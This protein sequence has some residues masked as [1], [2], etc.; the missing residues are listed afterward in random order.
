MKTF[1]RLLAAGVCL[2]AMTAAAATGATAAEPKVLNVYN[3]SDYI[4][5]DTLEKFTAETGI[6]VQYDVYDSNEMLE[7]KLFSGSSGYDVVVPT[8]PFMARQ[9]Q[10]DIL[11]PLD[12][13]KIPNWGKQDPALLEVLTSADPGNA[14]AAIY[15]W[16]TNGLGLNVDKIKAILGPD[17]PLDSYDLLFKPE[18]ASKLAECGIYIFD[19]A[20]EV[21]PVA[22]AYLGLDPNSASAE[23]YKKAEELM[24]SIRPYIRKFHSSEYINAIANGD[25]CMAMGYS[26]DIFIAQS[27]AEEA[28]NGVNIEY[29]IPKEGTMVWFDTLVI[30][31]DAPHPENAHAFI[32]FLL[33]PDIMAGISNYVWYANGVPESLPLVDEAVRTNPSINPPPEIMAKLFAVKPASQ[34][35]D[36]LRTRTF[37]RIKTGV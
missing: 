12:K 1:T 21:L 28:K 9:V 26:G 6:A 17:A 29:V 19:S 16:G 23:D 36:R 8:S 5:E 7:A 2:A 30:P 15:L 22:L 11:M 18:Y 34:D 24:L 25:I 31:K 10:A 33:R 35:L 37:A 14:H 27:R 13:A 4:G 32:D 20:F 3:W